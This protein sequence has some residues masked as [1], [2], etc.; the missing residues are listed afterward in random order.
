MSFA[1]F[2]P[3]NRTSSQVITLFEADEN[4]LTLNADDKVRFKVWRRD[5][6]V[7][8][9]D[10][11]SIGALAGGSVITV[12]QTASA[13]QVTL[14]VCQADIASIVPG[15]YSASV[16]VVDSGDSNLIKVAEFGTAAFFPSG[17]GSIGPT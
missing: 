5:Q 16:E 6:A 9:L 12:D 10:I 2:F 4:G 14:K 7:P 13:A 11:D 3:K 1:V 17:G 15:T 8:I